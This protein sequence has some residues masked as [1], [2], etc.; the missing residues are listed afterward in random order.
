M[1]ASQPASFPVMCSSAS[2]APAAKSL[3]RKRSLTPRRD[4]ARLPLPISLERGSRIGLAIAGVLTAGYA[5]V[6]VTTAVRLQRE[7][8]G[9]QA[10]LW[11]RWVGHGLQ[12]AERGGLHPIVANA[13]APFE[14]VP[15]AFAPD[16]SL[17]FVVPLYNRRAQIDGPLDGSLVVLDQAGH[18]NHARMSRVL[19]RF[20]V[21]RGG[22]GTSARAGAMIEHRLSRPLKA[23]TEPYYLWVTYTSV[24]RDRIPLYV[25]HPSG[26]FGSPDTLISLAVGSKQSIAWLGPGEIRG[27]KL[28]V[29]PG[30]GVC[31]KQAQVVTLQT[32]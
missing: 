18:V 5:A 26:Y 28:Q 13:P 6:T 11:E 22:C 21:A 12:A 1:A 8:P 3:R 20:P 2:F 30:M 24:G 27:F 10:R 23:S 29:F 16:N 14:I 4:D 7:W 17:S 15:D 9:H 32:I 31:I 25:D 19:A